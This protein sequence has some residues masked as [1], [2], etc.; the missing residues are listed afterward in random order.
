VLGGAPRESAEQIL[1]W[2]HYAKRE[3]TAPV[4]CE[5]AKTESSAECSGS[6]R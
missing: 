1:Q 5:R 6:G 4:I 3:S 2:L